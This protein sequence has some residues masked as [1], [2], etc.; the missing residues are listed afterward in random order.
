MNKL[1]SFFK[2]KYIAEDCMQVVV[3]TWTKYSPV[4]LVLTWF[5]RVSVLKITGSNQEEHKASDDT[6][7]NMVRGNVLYLYGL[8]IWGMF[9]KIEAYTTRWF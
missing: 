3:T 2:V 6:L 7:C 8:N 9:I 1:Y 4:D 5:Y